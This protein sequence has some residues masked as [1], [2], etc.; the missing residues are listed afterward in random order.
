M[1][2]TDDFPA[3]LI[4]IAKSGKYTQR[5]VVSNHGRGHWLE[6]TP[7]SDDAKGV[8]NEHF[9]PG[10][11]PPFQPFD[12]GSTS[13]FSVP[14]ARFVAAY[15]L[16]NELWKKEKTLY[17]REKERLVSSDSIIGE[18]HL[19]MLVARRDALEKQVH[20]YAERVQGY[21]GSILAVLKVWLIETHDPIANQEPSQENADR[22]HQ[23]HKDAKYLWQSRIGQGFPPD[24]L[25]KT[26][27]ETF[28]Q[29]GTPRVLAQA[30]KNAVLIYARQM[31]PIISEASI[32]DSRRGVYESLL[33]LALNG[34]QVA[35]WEDTRAMSNKEEKIYRLTNRPAVWDY[36]AELTKG[37]L[38]V[39]EARQHICEEIKELTGIDMIQK[40]EPVY[41]NPQSWRQT[42]YKERET[43]SDRT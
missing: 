8:T 38:T 41:S 40:Q 32:V 4:E 39:E 18:E 29:H 36:V 3:A 37:R 27:D 7:Y 34:A 31:A 26:L 28:F 2:L 13:S 30:Q 25:E 23:L 35:E 6:W 20:R 17:D 21:M 10:I 1:S 43:L 22:L 5:S 14:H 11:L 9:F 24:N 19:P 33:N 42:Y 12:Y 15:R 16:I